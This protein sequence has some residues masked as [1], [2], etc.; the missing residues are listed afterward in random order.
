MEEKDGSPD[1]QPEFSEVS[2]LVGE[3]WGG[4]GG[5][6][7]QRGRPSQRAADT[8]MVTKP[9][10]EKDRLYTIVHCAGTCCILCR[11]ETEEQGGFPPR[12]PD[13]GT[14]SWR[15]MMMR[16]EVMVEGRLLV[17]DDVKELSSC[18]GLEL[19]SYHRPGKVVVMAIYI[20]ILNDSTE[21]FFYIEFIIYYIHH[22]SN[23][24]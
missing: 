16:R 14:L 17:E 22:T 20:I 8:K 19:L 2:I 21:L 5:G 12:R 9:K 11:Q 23:L 15:R 10:H 3:E 6:A 24:C 18:F 13:I 1:S 4:A 7:V